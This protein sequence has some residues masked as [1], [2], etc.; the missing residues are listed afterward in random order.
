MKK[1]NIGNNFNYAELALF[2]PKKYQH[3]FKVNWKTGIFRMS[4][5]LNYTD[6]QVNGSSGIRKLQNGQSNRFLT[7]FSSATA[8][9]GISTDQAAKSKTSFY[10]SLKKGI[11]PTS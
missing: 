5:V 8:I 10:V 7:S 3:F 6:F 11:L 4:D 2:S 9:S 1:Y